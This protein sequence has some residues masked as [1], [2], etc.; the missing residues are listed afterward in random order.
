MPQSLIQQLPKTV[1]I[2][3]RGI[4]GDPWTLKIRNNKIKDKIGWSIKM[5]NHKIADGDTLFGSIIWIIKL[6]DGNQML[7]KFEKHGISFETAIERC[8]KELE[9]NPGVLEFFITWDCGWKKSSQSAASFSESAAGRIIA[10]Q[11]VE[12]IRSCGDWVE[13]E[14]ELDM[15]SRFRKDMYNRIIGE[16]Q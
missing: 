1:D 5:Y 9:E 2:E 14:D 11:F 16:Q 4:D 15:S 10:G 3:F 12:K 7:N 13:L 6:D 8:A